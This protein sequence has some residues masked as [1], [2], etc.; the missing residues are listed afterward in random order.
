MTKDLLAAHRYAEAL[1]EL[2]HDEKQDEAVEA[3]LESLSEALKD[4]PATERF[5]GNPALK[6]DQKR[7]I[8]EKLFP[9]G[10]ARGLLVRFLLLL[11]AK[12]RFYLIHDVAAHFRRVAD[13][14]QGQGVAEI[15]SAAP[16]K[17]EHRA[18]IVS[19]IEAIARKKMV[20]RSCVDASLLG[21]VVVRIGSRLID[22]SAANKINLIRKELT[23]T[24]VV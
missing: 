3:A 15:R 5:L 24:G 11:F 21:G 20:V 10:K 23:K 22:D 12:N 6:P 17:D 19:R 8:V 16:L 2:A 13:E 18:A 4:S 1:F 9:E 7:R 14:A